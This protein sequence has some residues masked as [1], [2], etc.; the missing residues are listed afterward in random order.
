[1]QEWGI[2]LIVIMFPQ[3]YPNLLTHFIQVSYLLPHFRKWFCMLICKIFMVGQGVS[4]PSLL[5][6]NS[7]V[8]ES[9]ALEL[10]R[11][12]AKSWCWDLQ[13]LAVSYVT[14][15]SLQ[16]KFW[17]LRDHNFF[18]FWVTVLGLA[19]RSTWRNYPQ[20]TKFSIT[21][22]FFTNNYSV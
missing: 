17:L 7:C 12:W 4:D 19:G 15:D 13:T 5:I 11:R 10:T 14:K 6:N 2:A 16:E 9:E 8:G 21:H 1:M 3:L 20:K 22:K 18:F